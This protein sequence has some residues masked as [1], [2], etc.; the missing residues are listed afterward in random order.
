MI[1]SSDKIKELCEN[2]GAGEKSLISPLEDSIFA[3]NPAKVELR[4][5]EYC[6]CSSNEKKIINLKDC[7]VVTVKPN[8][9]FLFQTREKVNMPKNLS[10]RMSLKM[11]LVSQGLLMPSQTQVDPGYSNYLFGMLYNLSADEIELSY[12]QSITTLEFTQTIA[13]QTSSYSGTM[14]NITFEQFV[15]TRITS[16]LGMLARDVADSKKKLD[17]SANM[18][19]AI[20]TGFSVAIGTIAIFVAVTSYTGAQRKSAEVATLEQKFNSLESIVAEQSQK[21]EEYEQ[22]LNRIEMLLQRSVV[23]SGES[24]ETHSVDSIQD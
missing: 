10:G 14:A 20:M 21:L 9:I 15:S 24:E 18:W 22:K 2:P 11:G 1:L 17:S 6:Y 16:S 23:G 3:G 8:E 12:E 4:L 7:H 5:G 13:N 19:N